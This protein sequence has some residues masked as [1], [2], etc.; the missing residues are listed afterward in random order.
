MQ[1]QVFTPSNYNTNYQNQ[2]Y[3][4]EFGNRNYQ[5]PQEKNQEILNDRKS[6]LHQ[7]FI[8]GENGRVS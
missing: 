3:R 4:P 7:E 6:D 2:P 8:R 1:G 5:K